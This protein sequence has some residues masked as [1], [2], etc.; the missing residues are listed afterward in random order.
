MGK[1]ENTEFEGT[2]KERKNKELDVL[3]AKLVTEDTSQSPITPYGF[4]VA[5]FEAAKFGQDPSLVSPKHPPVQRYE[6]LP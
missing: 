1:G 6:P 5:S 4:P 3:C 2:N